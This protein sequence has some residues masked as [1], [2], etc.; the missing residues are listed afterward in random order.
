[1]FSPIVHRCL[2][3]RTKLPPFAEVRQAHAVPAVAAALRSS[4][5]CRHGHRELCRARFF[6]FFFRAFHVRACRPRLRFE[7]VLDRFLPRGSGSSS[8]ESADSSPAGTLSASAVRSFHSPLQDLEVRPITAISRPRLCAIG[9]TRPSSASTRPQQRD[10]FFLLWLVAPGRFLS[11]GRSRERVEEESAA[12]P[13]PASPPCR[14]STTLALEALLS[15][16]SVAAAGLP[17]AW[18]DAFGS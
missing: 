16:V 10:R 9:S 2:V 14:A 5:R 15:A 3:A 7:A 12:R 18:I 17:L 8:T 4:G 13:A 1:L 11:S 6:F